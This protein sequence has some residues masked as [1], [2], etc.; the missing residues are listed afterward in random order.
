MGDNQ[1][2]ITL[3]MD[4]EP[5]CSLLKLCLFEGGLRAECGFEM[6]SACASFSDP[7]CPHHPDQP[8]KCHLIT[9]T[10]FGTDFPA[11]PLVIHSNE[12]KT[13]IYYVEEEVLAPEVMVA[14]Q[15]AKKSEQQLYQKALPE[16]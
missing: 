3:A 1:P 5:A 8:C 15:Q 7:F 12:A 14:L 9:L 10:V 6:S 11:V 2:I 16:K 4:Y 13:E